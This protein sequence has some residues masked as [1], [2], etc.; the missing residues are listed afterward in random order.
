[1]PSLPRSITIRLSNSPGP[2]VEPCTLLEVLRLDGC[3]A[4]QGFARLNEMRCFL[5]VFYMWWRSADE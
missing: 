4:L 3:K 2:L 1:L 5:N